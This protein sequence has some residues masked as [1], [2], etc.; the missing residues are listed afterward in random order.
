MNRTHPQRS[1]GGISFDSTKSS[2]EERD[3]CQECSAC[4]SCTRRCLCIS[5]I[6]LLALGVVGAVIGFAVTFGLP[7]PTPVNRFCVTSDD[8]PSN[9]PGYLIFRCSN[10]VYWIYADKKCNGANDCGDCSDEKGTLASCPPCGTQWWSCTPVFFEY[11]TC[12]PRAL[13]GDRIQHCSDWS[14]E[15]A[16]NR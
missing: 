14:D 13:C 1:F 10:P 7:P 12:I 6:A 5:I 3:R 15:Y 11:C 9:L 2:S 4:L 16:C 8:L